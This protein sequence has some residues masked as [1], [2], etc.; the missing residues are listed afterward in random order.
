MEID[1]INTQKGNKSNRSILPNYRVKVKFYEE[2][3][4]FLLHILNV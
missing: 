1:F 4:L 2:I 3:C